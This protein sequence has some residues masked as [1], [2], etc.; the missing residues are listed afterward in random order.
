MWLFLT[1][2][3][4]GLCREEWCMCRGEW[5]VR[6]PA[7]VKAVSFVGSTRVGQKV[8]RMATMSGKRVQATMSSK[9]HTVILPDANMDIAAEAVAHA[10]FGALGQRS[11]A[12][13]GEEEGRRG[14]WRS[15]VVD[16]RLSRSKALTP[17]RVGQFS[18]QLSQRW[19]QSEQ[20]TCLRGREYKK[21]RTVPKNTA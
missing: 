21:T 6:A 8:Y 4:S 16:G 15:L 9:N 5:C 14:A 18:P 3:G 7:D 20:K 12:L 1:G 11:M 13:S 17:Q 19:P 2:E 10:A